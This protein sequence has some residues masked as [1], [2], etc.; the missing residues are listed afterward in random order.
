MKQIKM[1]MISI[2]LIVVVGVLGQF[3]CSK[4]AMLID[5]SIRTVAD[6]NP[7]AEGRPSPVVVR[8]YQLKSLGAFQSADFFSLYDDDAQ[9][10]GSDLVLRDEFELQP[11]QALP[12]KLELASDTRYVGVI[13]AFRDLEKS[14]WRAHYALPEKNKKRPLTIQLDR[15]GV[16]ITDT[17]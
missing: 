8:V 14:R 11:S 4:P 3:G 17:K 12:Y 15:L 7:D 2:C 6:I 1:R 16:R 10:L 13:A 9:V 5:G